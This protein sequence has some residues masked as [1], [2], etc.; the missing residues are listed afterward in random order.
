VQLVTADAHPRLVA[1]IGAALPRATWQRCRSHY[2]RA[3]L[4]KMP[5]SAQPHVATQVRTI[6]DQADAAAVHTQF[7]R[8]VAALPE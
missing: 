1:A 6:L 4:T 2:L 5:K 3:L 8:V 7:D